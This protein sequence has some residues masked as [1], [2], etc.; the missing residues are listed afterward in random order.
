LSAA[1]VKVDIKLINASLTQNQCLEC[2]TPAL[3][4]VEILR[5]RDATELDNDGMTKFVDIHYHAEPNLSIF[6]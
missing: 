3:T 1:V 4:L 6:P 5:L 2:A